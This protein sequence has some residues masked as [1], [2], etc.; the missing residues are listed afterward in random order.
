M[1]TVTPSVE[2]FL[3]THTPTHGQV[4]SRTHTQAHLRTVRLL[5]LTCFLSKLF[6]FI[7]VLFISLSPSPFSF[8][9]S[10]ISFIVLCY[11]SFCCFSSSFM[12]DF[13]MAV[14]PFFSAEI[15][16]ARPNMLTLWG[17]PAQRCHMLR[18][19]VYV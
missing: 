2:W 10:H 15:I 6:I 13:V 19:C 12:P 1:W 17:C 11:F 3:H 7:Y 8:S 18:T 9:F 5:Q 14:A 16:A 4:L